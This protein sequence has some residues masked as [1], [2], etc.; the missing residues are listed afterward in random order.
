MRGQTIQFSCQ[1]RM[2]LGELMR[3]DPVIFLVSHSS[4]GGAQEIWADLAEGFATSGYQVRLMTLYPSPGQEHATSR[5]HWHRIEDSKPSSILATIRLVIK[6]ARIFRHERPLMVF[7]AMPAA[8][9][10]GPLAAALA[11]VGTHVC[12]SHHSPVS[13]HQR[14]LNFVDSFT[15]SLRCTQSIVAVSDTVGRSLEAKPALYRSKRKTIHNALPPHI[16]LRLQSLRAGRIPWK[17]SRRKVIA[18]GRLAEEKNYP[19][20]IRSASYMPDVEVVIVGAGPMEASLKQ[21]AKEL[22]ISTRIRFLGHV[23]REKTLE[24]LASADVFVQPSIFEGHSLA[25]LEAAKLGMPLVVSDVAA[26]IEAI[27]GADGVR[28]GIAVGLHDDRALARQVQRLMD[29]ANYYT[30]WANASV[31]LS[32]EA[33]Y[34]RMVSSYETLIAP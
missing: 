21:L 23:A 22:D 18:I 27:T 24:I 14:W 17:S 2:L 32:T 25:L 20:L 30:H 4:Q 8:N 26:Q 3:Q 9:I 12:I 31:Q 10:V 6:L 13:T 33:T 34:A 11:H 19:V 16:E 7:T 28:Y 5:L 15:G 1:F 29:D